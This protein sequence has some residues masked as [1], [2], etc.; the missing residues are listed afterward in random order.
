VIKPHGGTLVN[1]MVDSKQREK[2]LQEA[3]SMQ[4]IIV[5]E[6]D[7]AD[8]EMLSTGALSPLTGFMNSKDYNNVVDNIRLSD[9]TVWPVPI[10]LAVQ[11][12]IAEK[13]TVNSD[14]ALKDEKDN[15]LAVLTLEEKFKRD[16][17]REKT[18]IFKGDDQHPGVIAVK[19]GGN[20]CL[21]GKIK[22]LNKVKHEDF[23]EYRKDPAETRA[24]FEKMGWN[25]IVA[26]QTRN[27]IHRAH[28]YL[29]KSALNICDG[30]LIHPLMGKTKE[31]DI[32]GDVRMKCYTTL[33]D[34]YYPNNRVLLS[35]FPAWMRYAGPREAIFHALVRKNYG[36]THFIV[37]RDHAGVGDYY[38]T[39]DAQLVFD[40]FDIPNEIGIEPLMFEH[41]MWSKKAGEMVSLKTC[42]DPNNKEDFIFLS[43]TKV[44]EMLK[45]G[46]VPPQEFTRPEVAEVL[47]NSMKNN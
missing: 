40:E 27:P 5:D 28:E 26:F 37:G 7:I 32:P 15:I 22:M 1:L 38:G 47:I 13:L 19:Q 2:L 46:E 39:Y 11:D 44:R 45:N 21:A 25:R 12:E 10:V 36:C 43:G 29:T 6:Y 33:I 23:Q 16:K 35:I 4:Q 3:K 41:C 34:N 30:L 31:G 9:G 18:K 17:E 14:I 20:I 42:P 8:L 24:Y